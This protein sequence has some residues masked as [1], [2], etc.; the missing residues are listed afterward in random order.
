M[1]DEEV[2]VGFRFYPTEEELLSYYLPKK[3]NGPTP[4]IDRVI[5][6]LPIYDYNPWELP[7][8]N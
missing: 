2:V 5:P 1:D 4:A 7:R 6:I 3:L 8:T